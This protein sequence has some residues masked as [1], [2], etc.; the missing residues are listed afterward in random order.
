MSSSFLASSA[1]LPIYLPDSKAVPDFYRTQYGDGDDDDDDDDD[2]NDD[3]GD[4]VDGDNN[5]DVDDDDND[6]YDLATCAAIHNGLA[7]S[8]LWVSSG[9][10]GCSSK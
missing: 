7:P 2:D 10:P 6:D 8:L 5:D 3:D 1:T 4:D 9:R